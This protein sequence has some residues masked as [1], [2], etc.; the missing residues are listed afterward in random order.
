MSSH[1]ATL[2]R[3]SR[4]S[5][6]SSSGCGGGGGGSSEERQVRTTP[7]ATVGGR[8]EKRL[9]PKPSVAARKATSTLQQYGVQLA[10]NMQRDGAVRGSPTFQRCIPLPGDVRI[11]TPRGE[12]T[13]STTAPR[14]PK[15]RGQSTSSSIAS[16]LHKKGHANF[17]D[18]NATLTTALSLR[19]E[20]MHE[21]ACQPAL[22]VLLQETL[23]QFGPHYDENHLSPNGQPPPTE[24]PRT[25]CGDQECCQ[26]WKKPCKFCVEKSG[27]APMAGSPPDKAPDSP[28]QTSQSVRHQALSR[29][30]TRDRVA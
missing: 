15:S 17:C 25:L 8:V 26:W 4:S 13:Q 7:L 23:E 24:G 29:D 12:V 5:S 22:E 11:P 16:H 1:Q 21:Q 27:A 9:E 6:S 3:R 2:H 30:G 10:R 19:R 14:T 28:R 20:N 18:K